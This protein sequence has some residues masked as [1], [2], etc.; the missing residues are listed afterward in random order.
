MIHTAT[1]QGTAEGLP[2]SPYRTAARYITL[3]Y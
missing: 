3:E 2:I 1:L